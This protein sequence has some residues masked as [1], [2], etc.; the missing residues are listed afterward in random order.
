M[1]SLSDERPATATFTDGPESGRQQANFA[2]PV[3]VTAESPPPSTG[4]CNPPP[5]TIAA[6]PRTPTSVGAA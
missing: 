3:P 1:W 4:R 5:S 6:R 2:Q